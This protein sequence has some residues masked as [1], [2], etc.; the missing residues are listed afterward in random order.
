MSLFL[1]R[2]DAAVAG[3]VGA[4]KLLLIYWP[5]L[6]EDYLPILTGKNLGLTTGIVR[7]SNGSG[8]FL[9]Y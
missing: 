2:V 4:I 5:A 1:L 3:I 7:I 9:P 8:F 6:V